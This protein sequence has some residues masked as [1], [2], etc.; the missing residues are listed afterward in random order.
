MKRNLIPDNA[1][2]VRE[3][4][5]YCKRK[6]INQS[7]FGVL[8]VDDKTLVTRLKSKVS[9]PSADTFDGI[10]AIINAG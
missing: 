1:T 6:Q 4:M 5:A 9:R 8:S 3:I 10:Y 2:I 7:D